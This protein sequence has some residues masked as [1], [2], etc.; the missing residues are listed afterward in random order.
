MVLFNGDTLQD[1]CS[2]ELKVVRNISH[3][4]PKQDAHE[5]MEA[6]IAND[7]P[8]WVINQHGFM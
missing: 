6:T 7:F 8:N 2:H 3:A 5:E 1:V 4:L